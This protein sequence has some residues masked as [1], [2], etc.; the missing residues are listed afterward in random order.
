MKIVESQLGVISN[1]PL[2]GQHSL[3]IMNDD[4][5][6][7]QCINCGHA[8]SDRLSAEKSDIIKI[9]ENYEI[10]LVAPCLGELFFE[11]TKSNPNDF[12]N[13]QTEDLVGQSLGR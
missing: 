5:K 7:Q 1:C 8:T 9:L 4:V 13:M 12:L 3:H 10:S 11:V 6:T 2:C